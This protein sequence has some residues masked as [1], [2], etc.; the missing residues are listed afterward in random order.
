MSKVRK[1]GKGLR[2]NIVSVGEYGKESR[3]NGEVQRIWE[4]MEEYEW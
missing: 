4:S 1:F 2:I 3:G